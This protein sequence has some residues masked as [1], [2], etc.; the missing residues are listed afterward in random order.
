MS[1]LEI[2]GLAKH[3]GPLTKRI[4]LS[5][6]GEV[7]S[8]GSAC[9]MS[10][11][12][13][14]RINLSCIGELG[15][16][17][18]DME[19]NEAIAL[20]ALRDDLPPRCDLT[21]KARL[22]TFNGNTPPNLIARTGGAIRYHS[23]QQ[24]IALLDIDTKGTP[25]PIGRRI[26]DIGG[27]WSALVSVLPELAR[28][29][30]V[31]RAS[32]SA[33]LFRSDT[34]E[35]LPGSGGQHI[36][37][38]VRD[39]SD[40]D[41]FLKTLHARCWLHGFG[42]M[43]VG[44]GGQLLERSIVDRM[45]GAPERLVFEAAPLLVEPLA[46]D[47]TA[48][49]P[50]VVEGVAL[51]TIT[52]CPPLSIVEQAILRDLRAKEAHR[53]APDAKKARAAFIVHQS[54][55]LAERTGMPPER[56]GRIIAKQCDGV[57]LPD[58][59]LPFD[60]DDLAGV[61]VAD[62]LADPA[63]FEGA[64]LADP[65]EGVGYGVCK[66]RVMRRADGTPWINSFAHGRTVYELRLDATAAT[67]ALEKAPKDE[68]AEAFVRVVLAGQLDDAEVETLRNIAALRAGIGRRA[69]ERKLKAAR[70]DHERQRAQEER[71]RRVAERTDPR[72]QILAPATDAPW[73]PQMQVLNDVLGKSQE[74]EPPAR[75]IDGEGT[76]KKTRSIPRL[77]L[78]ATATANPDQ[79]DE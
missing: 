31:V 70:A 75:D 69:I 41:R 8:D 27:H 78:L 28:V 35:Q 47:Q 22:E 58:V 29:A 21:T 61:T 71:D 77:H 14:V 34:R 30:R 63:R 51:D 66:A 43:M 76:R 52:A 40:I 33:G 65:L 53:L 72:P 45:V 38:H 1:G 42:W 56:A 44:A 73:L 49:V 24:A 10:R 12:L 50:V 9:L 32:T 39:G 19:P 55:R 37:L 57:L 6:T 25:G 5:D 7:V 4:S 11:G 16:I 20:G 54:Q 68:V 3:N 23:Q 67:A 59:V 64:T 17:I 36:Y 26:V 18:E 15:L 2:T 60:D 79:G 48:R 62:V 13:A 46:Q 74:R